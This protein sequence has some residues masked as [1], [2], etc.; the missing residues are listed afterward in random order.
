MM[1]ICV[2]IYVITYEVTVNPLSLQPSSTPVR[3]VAALTSRLVTFLEKCTSG[4][5]EGY[6]VGLRRI[7]AY[8]LSYR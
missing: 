2:I 3:L 7:S 8:V 1:K 5:A 4:C 6:S